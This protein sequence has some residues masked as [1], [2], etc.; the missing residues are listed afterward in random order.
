MP[1]EERVLE[2]ISPDI[3]HRHFVTKVVSDL[4]R[5][6]NDE[7]KSKGLDLEVRLVGSVAK[8]TYLRNPDVDL[9]VMFPETT[10]REELEK[11][12]LAI[13]R[14]VLGGEERYAE[15]PYIH[16]S[17][18]GLE[19]DLVP[20]YKIESPKGL[21]SA[22][23]RTPFHT[24][25][26]RSHV[27]EKQKGEIRL[28]KQFTK[29]IGVYGAEAK[30]QGFSGYLVELLILKYGDFRKV[31]SEAS[32]W[33]YGET[34]YLTVP[35]RSGFD[36]PFIFIDPIDPR[37]NVGSAVSLDSFSLF[38]YGCREYLKKEGLRFFFPRKGDE[39]D[40]RAMKREVQSRNTRILIIEFKRPKIIDDDLYPQVRKT[41][42]GL[43]S[44]LDI[45]DFVIVDKA[46]HVEKSVRFIFELQT[47]VLSKCRRHQGPP[48][49]LDNS[50][51]FLSKWKGKM[52]RRPFIDGG[53][54]TA[55]A[56][57]EYTKASDLVR[58][59]MESV[60]LGRD[61]RRDRRCEVIEHETALSTTYKESL[62]MLMD[63]R[64]PWE[65]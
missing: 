46:F 1:I 59:Q 57:R 32:N 16:G 15:H 30:I 65:R 17:Y 13:G 51:D 64:K 9:F 54:W 27:S 34:L 8:D 44:L 14:S 6:T 52:T 28:L 55:I 29:G 49:W 48:V 4:I 40:L 24:D 53:R 47:D 33:R 7:I 21:K 3:K 37:R 56:E 35:S 43:K 36:S 2:K 22:V 42:D 62:K 18:S 5:R 58:S 31:L 61:F 45:H 60:G 63:K 23:D 19:V 20:C 39:W 12:G 41:L 25:F 38:I 50:K 10:P 11:V 26:I